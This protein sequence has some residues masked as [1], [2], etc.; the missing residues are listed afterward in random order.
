MEKARAKA[1]KL[2]AKKVTLY[3]PTFDC[4]GSSG[5]GS[6][7]HTFS[8]AGAGIHRGSSIAIRREIYLSDY[9][10]QLNLR[11]PVSP[12]NSNCGQCI[13]RRWEG[14]T[15]AVILTQLI[16]PAAAMHRSAPGRDRYPG[17]SRIRIPRCYWQGLKFSQR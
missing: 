14:K 8:L 1:L 16:H 5:I 10:G 15:G 11:R 17:K 12:W 2:G 13:S 7:P 4:S 3:H 9:S 6:H